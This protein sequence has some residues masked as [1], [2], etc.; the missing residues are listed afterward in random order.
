MELGLRLGVELECETRVRVRVA[1]RFVVRVGATFWVWIIVA[2]GFG[3]CLGSGLTWLATEGV[4]S[5]QG[6]ATKSML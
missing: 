3:S 2:E 6:N 5:G 1:V 4:F